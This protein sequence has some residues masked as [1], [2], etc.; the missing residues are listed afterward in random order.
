MRERVMAA[1]I[2]D[3]LSLRLHGFS[4]YE[5]RHLARLVAENL[6]KSSLP[7]TSSSRRVEAVNVQLQAEAGSD[8]NQ[9][10][11]QIVAE[12][13]RQLARNT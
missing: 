9:L 4:E 8:I 12:V 1:I 13:L 10:S 11:K 2:I 3:S 6:G 7:V 5:G